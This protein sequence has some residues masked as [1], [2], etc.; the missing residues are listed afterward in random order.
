MMGVRTN[1]VWLLVL[2]A[3][4]LGG[5]GMVLHGGGEQRLPPSVSWSESDEEALPPPSADVRAVDPDSDDRVALEP[6]LPLPEPEVESRPDVTIVG[7]ITD[8]GGRPIAGAQVVLEIGRDTVHTGRG[9]PGRNRV[10]TPVETGGDGR[11]SFAG[12][13]FREPSVGLQVTHAG[14]AP[15]V[16]ERVFD[17]GATLLDFGDIALLG[18]GAIVGT[19][20]DPDGVGVGGAQVRLL[21]ERSNPLRGWSGH[22][23]LLPVARTD[24]NGF[25][26]LAQIAPGDYR[27]EVNATRF[28][29]EEVAPITCRD[30]EEEQLEPIRLDTGYR[31]AGVVFGPDGRPVPNAEVVVT[32]PR[33][34]E[35]RARTDAE[36]QFAVD[37]LRG[38]SSSVRVGAE[39]FVTWRASDVDPRTAAPLTVRLLAGLVVSG[40]ARDAQ[41]GAPVTHFAARIRRTGS[42][43]DLTRPADNGGDRRRESGERRR[44]RWDRAESFG[45]ESDHPGGA[46]SFTGLDE[47]TYEVDVDAANHQRATSD[48]VE[49]RV[50]GAIPHV[51]VNLQP[52]LALSGLVAA[53]ADQRPIAGARVQ[54]V[55]P[56][57]PRP[58]DQMSALDLMFRRARSRGEPLLETVTDTEGRFA[59]QQAPPGRYVLL[60]Q[61]AGY[62][63]R[64]SDEIDLRAHTSGVTMQLGKPAALRGVVTGVPPE[65]AGTARVL[66][67]GGTANLRDIAVAPDG[68]YAFEELEPGGYFVRAFVGSMNAF[69][70]RAIRDTVSS[71]A[72]PHFDVELAEGDDCRLDLEVQIP[73]AGEVTGRILHNGAPGRGLRVALREASPIV[74]DP[75]ARERNRRFRFAGSSFDGSTTTNQNGEFWFRDVPEGSYELSVRPAGRSRGD[76]FKKP[77]Q[78]ARD[79][80]DHEP[81]AI[82]TC[83][84][85]GTVRAPDAPDGKS[86]N[87]SLELFA[88]A[89]ARPEDPDEFRGLSYTLRVHNGKLGPEEIPAG[90]YWCALGFRGRAR[91][92]QSLSL[93]AGA[94]QLELQAGAKP[95]K[96]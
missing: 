54:L 19:V 75:G 42:L 26:R 50:D 18:G 68:S 64:W 38:V 6:G 57:E 10:R 87:G 3:L 69:I 44:S 14:F 59:F 47:G 90:D 61:A 81:I 1:H 94:V 16:A 80:V 34:R 35:S 70:S 22:E 25:F 78:V 67:F 53:A 72:D 12:P 13:G 74:P 51:T 15:R 9:R 55:I 36:G 86:L 71:G 39:G 20:I 79:S 60:A 95:G 66:V 56:A 8:A 65:R 4:L 30:G 41:T 29:R 96:K 93:G 33:D 58:T 24:Q 92:E 91:V 82:E 52:G 62:A 21:A 37:H 84:L 88:G 28:L 85:S 32:A 63:E 76:W 43:P 46:F 77:V 5:V 73:P 31:I 89:D 2:A 48:P 17:T 27:V 11:F 45:E 40:V 7:R 49:A 23:D 83:V